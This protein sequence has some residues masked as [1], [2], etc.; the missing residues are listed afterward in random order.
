[1]DIAAKVPSSVRRRLFLSQPPG[2]LFLGW[3]YIARMLYYKIKTAR[4]ER[5]YRF[6]RAII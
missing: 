1:V 6:S 2:S 4:I 3:L 5:L